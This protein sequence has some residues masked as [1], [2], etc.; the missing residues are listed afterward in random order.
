MTDHR[1]DEAEERHPEHTAQ[2]RVDE[3]PLG[4]DQGTEDQLE[5]DNEVEED[6]LKTLNPEDPPA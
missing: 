3:A 2:G 1:P 4:G 6:M 5:A